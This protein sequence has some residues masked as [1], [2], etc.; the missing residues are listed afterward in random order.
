MG[1]TRTSIRQA[2]TVLEAEGHISREVGRGT[3]L[4]RTPAPVR[5]A[6][7]D[8][9]GSSPA[10]GGPLRRGWRGPARQPAAGRSRRVAWTPRT[11]SRPQT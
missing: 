3:F 8:L 9:A 7:G 5:A 2:L 11:G 6:D 1:A 10:D 4:R